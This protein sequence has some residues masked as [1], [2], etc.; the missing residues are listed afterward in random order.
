MQSGAHISASIELL[1]T[2]A[3]SPTPADRVLQNYFK[4]RRYIGGRDKREISGMVYGA[5]RHQGELVW[6]LEHQGHDVTPRRMLLAYLSRHGGFVANQLNLMC[7]GRAYNAKPLNATEQ[8][9]VEKIRGKLP[10]EMPNWA[11]YNLPGW[12]AKALHEDW[13]DDLPRLMSRMAEEAPVD[14]RVNTLKTTVDDM[15]ATLRAEGHEAV[16]A[17]LAPWGLRL[18]ERAALFGMPAFKNGLFEVQD[19]GSQIIALLSA[20][21][22]GQQ[23]VDFCAGAGGK[24]LAMAAMM[25]NR[26]MLTAGD[27]IGNKLEELKR[28]LSRAG[29]SNT[30]IRQWKSERD[31]WVKQHQGKLDTVLLDVPCS[32]SGVWR[33]NP[34]ARWRLT[35]QKLAELNRTQDAILAST[36]RMVKPGGRLIYA[37]CSV[38]KAENADRVNAFLAANPAFK[39]MPVPAVWAEL[40]QQYPQLGACPTEQETL[41]LTPHQ[42]GTDGF[43][44]AVLTRTAP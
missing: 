36:A 5:L 13:G 38:L 40:S 8:K 26:G 37:T 42:H 4:H 22:P 35:P 28:R 30:T 10:A 34:D 44:V 14:L 43:F 11:R 21:K 16:P 1:T 17:P 23:V 41:Q 12:L 19:A 24:T 32:G 9:M 7:D 33:R 6:L 25:N 18:T 39:I 2:I 3:T 20:V 29:V 27:I 31:K 15:T